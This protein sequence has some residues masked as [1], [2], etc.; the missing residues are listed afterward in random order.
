MVRSAQVDVA[1]QQVCPGRQQLTSP[2]GLVP[3]RHTHSRFWQV[4]LG[5]VHG[6]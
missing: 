5:A 1:S 3:G 2:H 4:R 6:V